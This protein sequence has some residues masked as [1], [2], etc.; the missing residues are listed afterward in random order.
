MRSISMKSGVILA[1]VLAL[2]A[3]AM[4]AKTEDTRQILGLSSVYPSVNP[5]PAEASH[6]FPGMNVYATSADFTFTP[7][8]V[9]GAPAGS[10]NYI[11]ISMDW[12]ADGGGPWSSEALFSL[13]D[14]NGINT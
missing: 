3:W 10:Y 11:D 5:T 9:S 14:S 2:P 1:A 7:F 4:A 13:V 6:A 8:D 12:Q